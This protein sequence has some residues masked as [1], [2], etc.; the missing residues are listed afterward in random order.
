MDLLTVAATFACVLGIAVLVWL[1]GRRAQRGDWLE[2]IFWATIALAA[3][4]LTIL[5]VK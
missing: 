5:L 4:A 3:L 1:A 2:A